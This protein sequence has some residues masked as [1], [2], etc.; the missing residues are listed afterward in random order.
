MGFRM[1]FLAY[2][3]HVLVPDTERWFVRT[4]RATE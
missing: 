4:A 3:M 2:P 1:K